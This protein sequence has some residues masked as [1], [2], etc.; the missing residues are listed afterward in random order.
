MLL[1]LQLCVYPAGEGDIHPS[2]SFEKMDIRSFGPLSSMR[3]CGTPVSFI[4][5][6]VSVHWHW[7]T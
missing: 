7:L 2:L 5:L 3:K 4:E 1:T 6:L